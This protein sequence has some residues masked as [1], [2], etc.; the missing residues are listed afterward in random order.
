M[1]APHYRDFLEQRP[2]VGWLEVHSENYFE[3]GGWDF[4]VLRQLRGDY[5][6]SLHGVGLGLGSADGFSEQHLARLRDLVQAIDP[7]LVSEH[8]C[9]GAV[10]ARHLNDLL[11]MPLTRAALHLLCE[12]VDHVQNT[13]GRT[14][15]LEN[16]SSYLRFR[17]DAMGETEFLAELAAR[18]GCG[19]LLDVNNLYVN[20]CNHGED[21][22]AAMRALTPHMVGEIHLAGHLVTPDAVVDHHGDRIAPPVWA[23]YEEALRRF[24]A[25]STLIEWDTDIP[26]LAVLLEQAQQARARAERVIDSDAIDCYRT[27]LAEQQRQFAQALFDSRATPHI[28]PMFDGDAQTSEQRF[29]L[30]RGNVSAAWAKALAAAYPV[31]QAL[32]GEE[33]FDALAKEYGRAYPSEA[34][35]LN[36]F[37]AGFAEFLTSFE[38]VTDYPYFPDM[39]RLEWA[40]HRA[41]Y[42]A[43][44]ARVEATALAVLRPEQLDD[45][46]LS[47]RPPC[48]LLRSG[49]AVFELWQAHQPGM[50]DSF[51][52][53]L[54]QANFGIVL[55]PL[56][57]AEA[58]QLSAAAFIALE[59]L[60]EGKSLGAALDA[61]CEVDPDFDFGANLRQWM[62]WEIFDSMTI[63]ATVEGEQ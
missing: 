33:F 1:R 45:V 31:L 42:A 41:H 46:L 58:M 50:G 39:A 53:D 63:R 13:L 12:R 22:L 37:G 14:I 32:V 24:G 21:A 59:A 56:W 7:N 52:A 62:Q 40:L 5:P 54:M 61:A 55:R 60:A 36:L 48:T 2:K 9:W 57:K 35:D 18:T 27:A 49:W 28:L 26:E 23:L 6:V 17:D 29:A 34:G 3:Q 8:L 4:H 43:S 11:P 47:L 44:S 19:I 20:Q 30:Y 10:G 25:V 16:V 15:L 51:P 38:H